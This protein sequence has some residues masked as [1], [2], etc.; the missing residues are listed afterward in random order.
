VET[1][2]DLKKQIKSIFVVDLKKGGGRQNIGG[3]KKKSPLRGKGKGKITLR[4]E[5]VRGK[6]RRGIGLTG[7][8]RGLC[9]ASLRGGRSRKQGA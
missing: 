9:T 8:E 2:R 3:S 4:W 7:R 6:E 1:L 5:I